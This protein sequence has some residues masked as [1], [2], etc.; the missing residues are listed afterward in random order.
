MSETSLQCRPM[1]A[2]DGYCRRQRQ[3]L[4]LVGVA[5]ALVLMAF[6]ANVMVGPVFLSPHVVCN[7]LFAPDRVLALDKTVIWTFRLPTSVFALLIGLALG[8]SGAEMQ[9][10]LDNP[11]ASPYTL[12]IAS[13][14]SFGAALA[15]VCGGSAALQAFGLAATSI[16]A[17]FFA[18]IASLLLWGLSRI[19]RGASDVVILC[20][21]AILFFFNAALALLQY[22]SS[23]SQSQAIV[24]WM[25]GSL[26]GVTWPK[27]A[28]LAGVLLLALPI[29]ATQ[30]WKLTA[31]RL[32]DDH[33]RSLGVDV[34]RLRLRTLLLTSLLTA[35]AVCFAGA[36]GFI[37]LV[38]PHL[39]RMLV[40]EE[41]RC[42]LPMS[43][44]LGAFL[45]LLASVASQVVIPGSIFP[46]GS[47]TA[48]IGIP[49]FLVLVLRKRGRCS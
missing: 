8:V 23:E 25:F 7:A 13:A 1:I 45:L 30:V 22:I 49:F 31:L 6:L 4:L 28:I 3:R 11:L 29:L 12:G 44:L 21:V 10:I 34:H 15:I 19:K 38:A 35:T 26:Q 32:G 43:G 47:A 27:I 48:A 46:I 41:Q 24:F 33:A 9:T 42:F 39:A 16:S 5:L 37:G 40:G 36:I 17:F 20:G 18:M 2:T 14:A